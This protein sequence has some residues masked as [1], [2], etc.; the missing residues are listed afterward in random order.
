LKYAKH[1]CEQVLFLINHFDSC[2]KSFMLCIL[3]Q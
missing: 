1:V 2:F 3:L